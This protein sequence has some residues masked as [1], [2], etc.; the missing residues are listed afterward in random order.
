VLYPSFSD[1]AMWSISGTTEDSLVITP[2][3]SEV[4]V[5]TQP[6]TCATDTFIVSVNSDQNCISGIM[7]TNKNQISLN[8]FPSPA[9]ENIFVKINGT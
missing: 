6:I 1:P 4:Y 2:L 3:I 8:V 7:E 9:S 5:A